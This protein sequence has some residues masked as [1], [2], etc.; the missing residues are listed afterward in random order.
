LPTFRAWP[1]YGSAEPPGR[2]LAHDPRPPLNGSRGAVFPDDPGATVLSQ[3]I[4]N[5]GRAEHPVI[6]ESSG[7]VERIIEPAGRGPATLIASVQRALRLMEAVCDH[8]HGAPAKVLAREA[9][10]NLATA[11]HLLRTLVYE[12]YLCRLADGSYVLSEGVPTLLNQSRL[13]VA[14]NRIRPALAALRDEV[15]AASYLCLYEDGEIVVREVA[16]GPTAPRVDLWVGFHDAGHAT[17]LGKCVLASLD[18]SERR[19]YLSR[20]DLPELTPRTITDPRHFIDQLTV[21]G[22]NGLITD[23]EEYAIGTACAATAIR[24]GSIVGAVALSV[25]IKRWPSLQESAPSLLRAAAR[26]SR[27]MAISV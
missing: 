8:E 19:D 18:L 15:G 3:S 25:P 24:T 12:G 5:E 9:G 7:A 11:Y 21:G 10:L 1:Y 22:Q 16:D 6:A 27:G 17:A 4:A 13:Q 14:L 23:R 20:H 2:P 26:V